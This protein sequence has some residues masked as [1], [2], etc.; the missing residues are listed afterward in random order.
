MEGYDGSETKVKQKRKKEANRT[1]N[2]GF[3]RLN[4]SDYPSDVFAPAPCRI[5]IFYLHLCPSP[6][7]F[8]DNSDNDFNSQL[9]RI[10]F[11]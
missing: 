6:F 10:G 11:A 8:I 4:L 9:K 3:G 7:I 5:F 2:V 1:K